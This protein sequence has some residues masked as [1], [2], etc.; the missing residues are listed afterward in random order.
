MRNDESS[1]VVSMCSIFTRVLEVI[2]ATGMDVGQSM[3][4]VTELTVL[5]YLVSH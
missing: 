1:V 3:W 4:L 5:R 2:L